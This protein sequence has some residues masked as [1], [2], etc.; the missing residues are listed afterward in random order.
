M[1]V[2]NFLV[3][4]PIMLFCIIVQATVA[5]WSV[6]H[7]MRQASKIGKVDRLLRYIWPLLAAMLM[8]MTGSL[9]QIS[10]WAVLFMFLGEFDELYASI[11]H[12]AVNFSSLGYGDVVMSTQWKLLG[13]SK[14]STAYSMLGISSAALMAILQELIRSQRP[15]MQE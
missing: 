12:S 10:L 5:F 3:A 2:T 1:T 13:L 9:V 6:R 15:A 8:M 7:F 11:Y 14:P 4:L